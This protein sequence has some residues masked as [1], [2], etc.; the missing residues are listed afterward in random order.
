MKKLLVRWSLFLSVV[1]STS[2]QVTQVRHAPALNGTVEG[3]VQQM[4][5]ESTTLNGGAVVTGDL[6]VPG[7]PAV[8]LNG[9]PTYGGTVDGSGAAT[10]TSH[11]ITLNGSARLGHVVRRTDAVVLPVVAAPP[12]PTG[13]A[14]VVVSAAGQSVTWSTVRDLTLNSGVGAYAVPPGAYG[15][16][17]ASTGSSLTLG[18]VGATTPAVYSFQ[19]LTLNANSTLVVVGPVVV[20]LANGMSANGNLGN[21]A[22]PEWFTLK[23]AAGGLTLSGNAS[24]YAYVT[25]P[26]GPVTISG[27]A[28]LVGG[29]VA[30]QLTINGNGLLRLLA[31]PLPFLAN[32]ESTE[33]YQPGPL[34]G[35][36]GWSVIGPASIVT[37][38]VYAGQQ[39]VSVPPATPPPLLARLFVNTDARVTYTDIFAQPVAAVAAADGVFFETEAARVA[40]TVNAAANSGQLQAFNGTGAGGGTW[41]PTGQGPLLAATGRS[42]DWLRLT[43]RTDYAAQRWDLYFNGRMIAANLGFVNQAAAFTS[44]GLSGHTAQTTG[45][46]DLL[47]AFDNPLFADADHD[48]MEDAWETAHGL[49]PALDDRDDDLDADGLTNLLEYILGTRPDLADS[50][51]DGLPDAQERTLGTNPAS[52]DSDGDGLPDG[53]ERSHGL[54]PLSAADAAADPDGDG[55]ST[56]AEYQAGT[57]PADYYN[58]VLATTRSLVD[59][60]GELGP[61][62]SIAVWVGRGDAQPLVNAPVTFRVKSGGHVLAPSPAEAGAQEIS[63]RS[64]ANGVAR[65]YVR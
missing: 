4:T 14:S 55:V 30:D 13:T 51:G 25:A 21:S 63:V 19:H 2:A 57:D 46:D 22:H 8:R 17:T 35:Q 37:A 1:C 5:A 58:G 15:D 45:F 60:T 47:I 53:W 3:S 20:T 36:N 64:D 34:H 52:A 7:T 43:T 32:F 48:G 18:V 9:T 27:N 41:L 28:Q 26:S 16:F 49:N 24:V 6:L 40:L 54:D 44:L 31:P 65:A 42:A 39:A 11:Q 59:P 61:D 38:P 50:D 23:F 62:G 10:P 56:L 29:L 12:P 33:G